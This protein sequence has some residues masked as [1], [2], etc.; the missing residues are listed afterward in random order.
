MVL[1]WDAF[2]AKGGRHAALDD[3]LEA[4][5]PDTV[6]TYICT[7]GTTGRPK[8]VMLTQ[9]NLAWT[10]AQARELAQATRDDRLVSYLPLSHV[11]EQMFT[12]H[13]AAVAGY[14][15]YFAESLDRLNA[16][17]VEVEPTLF[18]GVP[19]VWEKFHAG[20][21]EKLKENHG[22]KAK[23]VEQATAVGRRVVESLCQGQRPS[24]VDSAQFALFEKLVERPVQPS[25]IA[26]VPAVAFV[27][28]IGTRNGL[29]RAGPLSW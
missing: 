19:R 5:R 21:L 29:T 3:R 1:G 2:M 26:T 6:T 23:L 4:L 12:I 11:A 15:V 16:N 24:I 7:S 25:C 13:L 14:P 28:I 8:A 20:V 27:I 22:V 17:L 10:A 9:D 18:F